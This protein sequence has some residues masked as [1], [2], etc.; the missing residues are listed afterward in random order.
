MK[1]AVVRAFG[2][3]LVIHESRPLASVDD[4]IDEVLPGEAEARIVVG[5]GAG[6]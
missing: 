5:L 6:R 3:P 1:A 4:S 2:E